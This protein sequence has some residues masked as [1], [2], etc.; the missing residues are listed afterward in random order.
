MVL[1]YRLL[2][3]V[4]PTNSIIFLLFLSIIVGSATA[5]LAWRERPK[6]GS[7][8]L[9]GL[10]IGQNWWS[11]AFI[12][13]LQADAV[14]TK[15]FWN[16]IAW[17]GIAIIPVAWLLFSLEYAG[18]DR[19]LNSDY[20][21]LIAVIPLLTMLIVLVWPLQDLI[22]VQ[23]VTIGSNGLFRIVYGGPWFFI[24]S[25]YTYL[26]G[27]IG[28][29]V[30]LEFIQS[31][32]L[33]FR[34]QALALLIGMSV[35]Y[36][37]NLSYLFNVIPHVG[38][39]P[40]PIGFSVSGVAFLLA[41]KRYKLL[42]TS[43]A[44]NRQARKL[45][46]DRMQ[47]GMVV[48]DAN[49]HIVNINRP[50]EDFFQG[51]RKSVLGTDVHEFIPEYDRIPIEG[52]L[53][54]TL[55]LRKD[56]GKTHLRVESTP[57]HSG[58]NAIIGRVISIYDISEFVR[59]QQRL[60]VL[61]RVHRH[62]IRTETNLILGHA[63]Q[64]S[65]E[66][67]EVVKNHARE[68]ERIGQKSRH[69]IDLFEKANEDHYPVS[70]ETVIEGAIRNAPVQSNDA[71]I[72]FDGA[73]EK[74]TVSNLLEAPLRN[75]IENAVVHGTA[76]TVEITTRSS[77]GLAVITIRD[78]GPGI[79]EY[80]LDVIRSGNETDLEH[81]SGLGLWIIKWGVD[82]AGGSVTFESS[83]KGTTVEITAPVIGK[84]Q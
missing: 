34:R 1:H 78:D 35:P 17:V 67:S 8:P 57:I 73:G 21:G 30:L 56:N 54:E 2:I 58:Q 74:I 12:F 24:I 71:K 10:L 66:A 22:V 84:N 26:L 47:E 77:D 62:N 40:T 44:A 23:S 39:D 33:A 7:E 20:I 49:D 79:S 38:I 46:F 6:P 25:G 14:S 55:T 29:I 83:E 3:P 70:L 41:I 11:V 64:L 60:E 80:E 15:L 52:T 81:G 59:R 63:E 53:E 19:M 37:T 27:V 48:V 75:V 45:V 43:P 42:D 32:L 36:L 28:I 9:V 18:R 4:N 76:P 51:N 65:G 61:N 16:N 50:A 72:N 69:A 31:R 82:L 5:I 68:I 13:R